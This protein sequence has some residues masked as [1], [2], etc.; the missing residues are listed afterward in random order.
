MRHQ[1]ATLWI[2][3]F[4]LP[5]AFDYKATDANVS[6]FAQSALVIP[7]VAAGLALVLIAPRFRDRSRL[8]STI[9]FSLLLCV[10]G[11]IV[12]QFVQ[13]NDSGNYLRVLLPFALFC[14]AT[15]CPA[16]RGA[17]TESRSSRK[18]CSLRT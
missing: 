13:D 3:F 16:A 14:W 17:N 10:L 4:L 5:L 15:S 7:A 18:P 9:T 11:S 12:A 1:Y 2:W 6:H 8:R